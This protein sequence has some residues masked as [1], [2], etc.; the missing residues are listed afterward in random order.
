MAGHWGH[1][2]EDA[3][4][5]AA[6]LERLARLRPTGREAQIEPAQQGDPAALSELAGRL[7]ALIVELR[8]ALGK[9]AAD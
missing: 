4:R 6:A 1:V 9:D 3:A 8:G 2:E 5:L 7:D